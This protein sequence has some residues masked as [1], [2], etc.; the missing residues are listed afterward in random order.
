MSA[1]VRKQQHRKLNEP[2]EQPL[3]FKLRGK[4]VERPKIDRWMQ[5]NGISQDVLYAPCPVAGET[6][7]DINVHTGRSD[8]S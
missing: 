3:L 8:L 7:A 4:T 5:R 1:I 6:L 2:E